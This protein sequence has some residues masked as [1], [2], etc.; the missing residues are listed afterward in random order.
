[1]FPE[2]LFGDSPVMQGVPL[3]GT[4]P[5]CRGQ[6]LHEP[7]QLLTPKC[8][9]HQMNFN[10]NS[11]GTVPLFVCVSEALLKKYWKFVYRLRCQTQ[12]FVNG[13]QTISDF[14]KPIVSKVLHATLNCKVAKRCNRRIT[15]NCIAKF[16]VHNE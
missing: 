15:R 10:V 13:C 6:S 16:V 7:T 3:Q 11:L 4:V 2:V 14:C 12:Y 5:L 8:R 9:C 1:M